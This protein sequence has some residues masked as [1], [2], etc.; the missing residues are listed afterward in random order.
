M[1]AKHLELA[2]QAAGYAMVGTEDYGP[3]CSDVVDT[4]AETTNAEQ[5]LRSHGGIKRRDAAVASRYQW[6]SFNAWDWYAGW[7]GKAAA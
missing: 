3:A 4:Q 6:F 1:S 2:A 5:A 7:T